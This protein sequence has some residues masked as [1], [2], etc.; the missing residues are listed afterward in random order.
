MVIINTGGRDVVIDKIS[1]RGQECQWSKVYYWR[2]DSKTISADLNVTKIKP[3]E[4]TDPAVWKEAFGYLGDLTLRS[5]WTIVIYIENP[6]SISK[7]VGQT[8][9]ITVFTA[10][11]RTTLKP[12]LQNNI[13]NR[14]FSLQKSRT[15]LGLF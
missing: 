1:V 15:S 9:G 6:D 12:T 11:A 14:P 3:S 4:I 7:D 10:N 5:G 13:A 2:T 8:V